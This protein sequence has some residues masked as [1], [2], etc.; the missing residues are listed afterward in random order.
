MKLNKFTMVKVGNPLVYNDY[1]LQIDE[2]IN[3]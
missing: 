1:L 2:F 3:S